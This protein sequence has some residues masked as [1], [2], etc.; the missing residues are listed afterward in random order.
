M[1]LHDGETNKRAT[2]TEVA[3]TKNYHKCGPHDS[4]KV[5]YSANKLQHD[6]CRIQR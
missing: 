4:A 1:Q 2:N 6:Y 3:V 5:N